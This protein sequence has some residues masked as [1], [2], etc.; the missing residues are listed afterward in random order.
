DFGTPIPFGKTPTR[1]VSLNPT[2]TEI[3]FAIGAGKRL[4]GRSQYDTFPDSAKT[5]PSLGIALRPSVEAIVAARPDLVILYASDD[6][7][8]ALAR[9]RQAGIRTVAFKL[10]SIE[11]FRRDTRLLGRLTGDSAR[12]EI[13]VDSVSVT[14][15]RVR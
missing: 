15:E 5:V 11:Q 7:R 2:T 3:L 13:V 8:P 9:L 6:N 1:I 10:D 14:L 12:A 4:V